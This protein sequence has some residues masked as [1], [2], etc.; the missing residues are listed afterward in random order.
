MATD[1]SVNFVNQ[2]KAN[3]EILMQ[4]QDARVVPTVRNDTQVGEYGYYEQ[5]PQITTSGLTAVS[6]RNAA[7]S[8]SDLS[9]TR[10]R[11][12][13]EFFPYSVLID[14]PD[15]VRMLVDP[16]ND[17]ARNIAYVFNRKKDS[18]IITAMDATAYTG[19]Q[20][21]TSTTFDANMVIPVSGTGTNSEWSGSTS[22]LN[23]TKL[24]GAA[25][26]L[27]AGDIPM[28]QRT[29]LGN[30]W[31]KA[32]LL[33]TTQVTSSDYAAVKALVRGEINTFLGFDFVWTNLIA[34]SGS[35]YNCFAYHRSAMMFTI[36]ADDYGFNA[37][38]VENQDYNFA[39]HVHNQMMI[40]ATRMDETA[41]VKVQCL[42]AA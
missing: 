3:I 18:V 39:T 35:T 27:D 29:F 23:I 20:G 17:V 41:I 32:D 9:P 8:Y 25:Y 42:N 24:V 1:W 26:L 7:T 31:Q 38:I 36:G 22:N 2:Y 33:Q 13:L 6:S 10:R 16:S 19:K 15:K 12:G 5:L 28:G 21:G 11:I 14:N 37:R 30:P 34:I 4:Q 40:G